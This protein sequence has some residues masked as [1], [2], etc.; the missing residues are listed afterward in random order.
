M[1]ASPLRYSLIVYLTFPLLLG[2]LPADWG[3]R[4]VSQAQA[5]RALT[6]SAPAQV[7]RDQMPS[8]ATR[9]YHVGIQS[10]HYQESQMPIDLARLAGDTGTSGG[11]RREVD[12]NWDVSNRVAKLLQDQGVLV[13]VLPATVPSGYDADAF[14]AIHADG[15]ASPDPRGFKIST[16]WSSTVAV[17]DVKLVETLTDLYSADTGLPQ[18]GN[19][20]RNMRGYYAYTSRRA[21]YRISAFTPAAIVE[22]GYM[23]NAADR[24][25]L[26]NNTDTVAKG[27][28]DGIMAYL[29]SSYGTPATGKE[30]G[31]GYGLVD[32]NVNPQATPLPIPAPGSSFL[33]P[34]PTPDPRPVRGN[35]Q[36]VLMGYPTVSVYSGPGGAGPVLAKLPEG[37]VLSSTLR[38]SD[39]YQVTL[40]D[41]TQG[42]VSRMLLV[43]QQ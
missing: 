24:A 25:V 29:K 28:A 36:V 2:T 7:S 6:A 15:N 4:I 20:T 9:P 37:Q 27:I 34:N 26:F 13:D 31:Y 23:T 18:D 3:D 43:V 41:S 10:G 42:W 11:G 14:V 1:A 22:M 32:R 19:V 30:Y 5:A 38:Q 40:R 16:R 35:W 12:L 17:Q 8:G 33:N 21:N 39:Y